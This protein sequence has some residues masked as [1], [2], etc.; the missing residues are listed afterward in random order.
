[1]FKKNVAGGLNNPGAVGFESVRGESNKPTAPNTPNPP[2][3][4]IDL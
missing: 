3:G 2:L 1:M 4:Y